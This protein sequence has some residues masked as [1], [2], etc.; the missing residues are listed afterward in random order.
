MLP[1]LS[2]P[3]KTT[4]PWSTKHY[5]RL[6]GY[7]NIKVVSDI[8]VQN[9]SFCTSNRWWRYHL[10]SLS[11]KF[12]SSFVLSL[13][14]WWLEWKTN[15]QSLK[16]G[17]RIKTKLFLASLQQSCA[18]ISNA[19]CMHHRYVKYT[20]YMIPVKSC[21]HVMHAYQI[22]HT[23]TLIFIIQYNTRCISQL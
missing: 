21:I 23:T 17:C 1:I 7:I 5:P 22:W 8:T 10:T 11:D 13:P 4:F 20:I 19:M 9:M 6:V 3:I 2:S 15:T 12:S 18:N 16:W 14:H